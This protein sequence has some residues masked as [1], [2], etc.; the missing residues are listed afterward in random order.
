MCDG[1]SAVGESRHRVP[2]ADPLVNR[3]N[4]AFSGHGGRRRLEFH[5]NKVEQRLALSSPEFGDPTGCFDVS[6]TSCRRLIPAAAIDP[7]DVEACEP[8]VSALQRPAV[9]AL[10]IAALLAFPLGLAEVRDLAAV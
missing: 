5:E 1:T 4:L 7:S 9:E 2:K 10:R 3:L 6:L 8:C